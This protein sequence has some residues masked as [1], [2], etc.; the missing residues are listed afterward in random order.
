MSEFAKVA[1]MGSLASCALR[2]RRMVYISPRMTR[3]RAK[4]GLVGTFHF[5]FG[6]A[7]ATLKRSEVFEEFRGVRHS[8]LQQVVVIFFEFVPSG[9]VGEHREQEKRLFHRDLPAEE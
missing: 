7:D 9:H 4:R 3:D 5:L 6:A 8:P 2:P 1:E